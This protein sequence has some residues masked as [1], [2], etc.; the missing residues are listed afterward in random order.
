M[1]NLRSLAFILASAR[2]RARAFSFAAF[3]SDRMSG[4][5]QATKAAKTAAK[6]DTKIAILSML[7]SCGQFTSSRP[8]RGIAVLS[9][10]EMQS[11]KI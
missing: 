6:M 2:R 11:T 5:K 4:R 10:P 3:D 1:L 7:A 9:S 8:G